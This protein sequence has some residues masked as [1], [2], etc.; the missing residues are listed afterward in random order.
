[1]EKETS[2]I[3][4][5]AILDYFKKHNAGDVSVLLNDLH[6]EIDCLPDPEGFLKDPNNWISSTVISKL[7]ERAKLILNDD[8][9]GFK[10]ARHAVEN[11]HLGYA[12]RI[13]V[14]A[15]WSI[16][17]GL[18]N[19][20]K[21]NDKWNR[22]KKVELVTIKR[23]MAVVRLHWHPHMDSSKD[24]CL[25]NQG[26]YTFMPRVWGGEPAHSKRGLLLF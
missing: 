6:P 5:W 11:L 19:L 1:M 26:A 2:C 8:M 9:V 14:K 16:H 10:A 22:N 13:F 24:I 17:T 3:N 12:Q 4:S 7:F 15:F 20:Q 23:N 18:K 25:Y 21:I